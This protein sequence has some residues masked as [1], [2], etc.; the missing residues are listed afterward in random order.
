MHLQA[1]EQYPSCPPLPPLPDLSKQPDWFT[2]VVEQAQSVGLWGGRP[3]ERKPPRG[4]SES[5]RPILPDHL[6][7][8]AAT[9]ALLTSCLVG[10]QQQH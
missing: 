8:R 4:P 2:A 10:L 1:A 5:E 9:G 6:L 7:S 3:V